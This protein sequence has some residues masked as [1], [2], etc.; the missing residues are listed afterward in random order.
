MVLENFIVDAPIVWDRVG[1]KIFENPHVKQ[2]RKMRVQI[3]NAGM[4]EDL[5]GYTLALGWKHTVSG[6]D[7]LDVFEDISEANVGIFEMAYTENLMT[8]IGKLKAS[9]VLTSVED[10]VVAESNDFYVK[11]DDSPFGADA[12]QGVGSY[13]RLAQI[14]LNEE[15]RQKAYLTN[16][17]RISAMETDVE[18]AYQVIDDKFE[19]FVQ[20]NIVQE[21]VAGIF[22]N[23]EETYAQDLLSVKSG[24]A[25]KA[26]KTALELEK[27]RI[28][29]LM[30]LPE[31]ATTNDA[32]L[33]DIKVGA[34]GEIY[35]SPAESVR[36]QVRRLSG[37]LN[38]IHDDLYNTVNINALYFMQS[39]Y[40]NGSGQLG[41]Y[42]ARSRT[43][44]IILMKIGQ[45]FY[46][47]GDYEFMVVHYNDNGDWISNGTFEKIRVW[48]KNE[49]VRIVIRHVAG[50]DLY[51]DAGVLIDTSFLSN[52][53]ISA[54]N[55]LSVVDNDILSLKLK[56]SYL[57]RPEDF[58]AVGD[59]VTD[60]TQA[61]FA[62]FNYSRQNN[63]AF[64]Y[65]TPNKTYL[66]VASLNLTNVN[67][68]FCGATIKLSDTSA[69]QWVFLVDD[70]AYSNT[71]HFCGVTNMQVDC[72]NVAGGFRFLHVFKMTLD[73]ITIKNCHLAGIWAEA[74]AELFF[75]N[76]HIQGDNSL[77]SIGI[78]MHTSDCHFTNIIVIDFH[79][80]IYNAG[81][82]YYDKIHGWLTGNVMDSIF[83]AHAS[84]NAS[85]VQCQSD[86]YYKSFSIYTSGG[87]LITNCSYFQNG[88]LYDAG[89]EPYIF[90]FEKESSKWY[91][92]KIKVTNSVFNSANVQ[93]KFSNYANNQIQ[94]TNCVLRENVIGN[95]G[96]MSLVLTDTVANVNILRIENDRCYL[97]LDLNLSLILASGI[98]Y[99]AARITGSTND[100]AYRPAVEINELCHLTDGTNIHVGWVRI[101]TSGDV[102]IKT[103]LVNTANINRAIVDLNYKPVFIY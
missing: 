24:L 79:T 92:R 59:G 81:T 4:V 98:E 9:L 51:N 77:S 11:V 103:N 48:E 85:L 82:N 91:S 86:T 68:D 65:G 7:G 83:F 43:K 36:G 69:D 47:T 16:E 38:N 33:E 94:L 1:K 54:Q 62:L 19:A 23:L 72:S 78:S 93:T 71:E 39:G 84:G 15:V 57:L 13:T 53:F 100:F 21:E 25:D 35:T 76:S 14:L 22:N 99:K 20:T 61:L 88:S 64:V 70:T 49:K 60:D 95:A 41:S 46:T 90:Y 87:L 28:D 50:N 8:N 2:G 45:K 102:F 56:S 40:V 17:A 10:M 55:K 31:G 52:T 6:V 44:D 27:N 5:S 101:N 3:T 30:S 58:G 97:K 73:K 42:K 34:N 67:A 80:A 96:Q 37:D 74:G 32:R 63:G 12:E 89:S 26:E 66:T 75:I 29:N 18:H